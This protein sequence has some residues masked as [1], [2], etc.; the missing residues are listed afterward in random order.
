MQRGNHAHSGEFRQTFFHPD[1]TVG[2]GVAPDHAIAHLTHIGWR[3]RDLLVGY[4]TG[5]DLR[6]K[7]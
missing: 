5:R 1:Y 4:T 7:L 2:S 6:N 3:R